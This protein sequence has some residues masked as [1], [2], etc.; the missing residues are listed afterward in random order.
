MSNAAFFD[1]SAAKPAKSIELSPFAPALR[2][3]AAVGR[4]DE[5][6]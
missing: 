6:R 3:R 1:K 5:E 4:N 2:Q